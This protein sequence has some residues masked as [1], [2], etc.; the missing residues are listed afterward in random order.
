MP[1]IASADDA[2][3]TRRRASSNGTGFWLTSYIGANRYTAGA[4]ASAEPGAIYPVAFLVEQ[5]A[6]AVVGAHYHQA[7]QFQV[8]VAG[9]GRLG[10]HGVAAAAVHFAGAWSPYGPLVAGDEGLQYFTLRNG[11]DPGARYM[12]FPDNRAARRS[13]PRRHR[14]KVGEIASTADGLWA[15]RYHIAAGESVAGPNPADGGGQFWLVLSGS[16]R[17]DG[18]TVPPRSCVF[19]HPEEPSLTVVAGAGGLD[20]MAM[21]FPRP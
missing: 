16:L 5:D 12:E 1:V 3:P 11:W 7:D 17:H 4:D 19:V 10:T 14:E 8:M 18:K 21:Q 6:D 9:N 13:V 20:A 2:C 15:R